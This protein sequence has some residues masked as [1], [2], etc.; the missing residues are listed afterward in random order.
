MHCYSC[1]TDLTEDTSA[2]GFAFDG[3]YVVVCADKAG[4]V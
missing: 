4:C 1:G 3:T 2:M